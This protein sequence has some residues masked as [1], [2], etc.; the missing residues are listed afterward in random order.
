MADDAA[1]AGARASP[2]PP[3]PSA[4]TEA[5]LGPGSRRLPLRTADG[6]RLRAAVAE[7]PGRAARGHV[8]L[9]HGRTEFL[10]KYRETAPKL[11]AR[12]FA[13]AS[14]DWR[15]QGA[16]QRLTPDPRMGHVEDFAA[17]QTDLA[18][19]LA[20]PE[21]AALPGPRIVFAHSM[22]GCVAL[23]ALTTGRL[24]EGVDRVI[25]SAPM[26]GLSGTAGRWGGLAA[27]IACLLGRGRAYAPGGGPEPYVL[28]PFGENLLT[29][30]PDEYARLA[31]FARAHPDYGLG[32]PSWRWLRAATREMRALRRARLGMR[33]LVL[34][35]GAE[36][37][38]SPGAIRAR[39]ARDGLR[40]V[41]I[42]G[43]RHELLFETP[44]RRAQAWRAIDAFLEA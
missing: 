29:G 28:Q 9:L 27:E 30:D 36:A 11:L 33:A 41:E 31:D 7:P 35:G 8:L 13:V 42:A 6:L 1:S 3:R 20:A 37:V 16:S 10:E 26:W 18:A 34:V 32:G 39:A 38:V 12:G 44:D 43:G 14:A 40:L 21:V 4:R 17:Y 15:G 25:F 22:G 19:L 23:R 24:R 5:P 2:P